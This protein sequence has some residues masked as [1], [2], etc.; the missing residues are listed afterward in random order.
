MIHVTLL[1]PTL[2]QAGAE[3][4]LVLLATRLSRDE[5]DVEVVAL[6]RSG[7]YAAELEAAGIPLKV[8]GK[9]WKFD[10]LCLRRLKRHLQRHQ[11]D[12]LH[13]WLF[14]AN[15]YGRL[16][17]PNQ[18]APKVIVSERCVDSWKA[19]W[20]LW[21]DRKLIPK[22]NLLVGNSQAVADFYASIGIPRERLAVVKNGIERPP[23]PQQSREEFRRCLNVAES[24]KVV[25]FVGRLAPQKRLKDLLWSFELLTNL[26]HDVTFVIV[27]DGPQRRELEEFAR[28]IHCLDRVRFLGHRDDAAS[29]MSLFDVFWLAS[30]FEGQSNSLLEAM[31]SGVPCIVSDIAA[32]VELVTHEQTGLVVP[33]GDRVAFTKAADRLLRETDFARQLGQNAADFCRE[34]LSVERMANEYARLYREVCQKQPAVRSG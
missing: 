10:P 6:T 32:N 14:A 2:D 7:P 29:L 5:F 23:V 16:A 8:L 3:K 33:T 17:L 22:T 30:D 34:S 9:R 25:G 15:A 12:V 26:E 28:N 1:I 4:Q 13:T 24:T 11:P 31:A 27:G 20:Q 21:L 18:N 19:D